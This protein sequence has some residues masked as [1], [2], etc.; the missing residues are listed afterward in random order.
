MQEIII[1]EI[2][3]EQE[4]VAA[5]CELIERFEKKVQIALARLWGGIE[6]SCKDVSQSQSKFTPA[7][8]W[9]CTK[10]D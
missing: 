1:A 9:N 3:V 6:R 5:N 2:E 7:D 10:Q 8:F 4:L